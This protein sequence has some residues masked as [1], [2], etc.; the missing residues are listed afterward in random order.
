MPEF[1]RFSPAKKTVPDTIPS[2][3]IPFPLSAKKTVPDTIPPFPLC[4]ENGT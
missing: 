2:D 4:E 3:T 1:Y